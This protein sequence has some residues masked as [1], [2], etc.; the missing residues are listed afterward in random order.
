VSAIDR[1]E[2]ERLMCGR[3]RTEYADEL[4]AVMLH[5]DVLRTTWFATEPPTRSHVVAKLAGDIEH[6]ERYSFGPWLLRDRAGGEMVGRGGL[7]HTTVTGVDEVEIGWAIHPARWGEGLATEVARK[8]I[9]TASHTCSIARTGPRLPVDRRTARLHGTLDARR[10]APAGVRGRAA[11]QGER[12][13]R[14]SRST[15]AVCTGHSRTNCAGRTEALAKETHAP[16]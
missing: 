2:A 15:D 14:G 13:G 6:W 7:K 12:D 16:P 5:P 3:G 4:C 9:Q 11:A 1:V 8:S 10:R